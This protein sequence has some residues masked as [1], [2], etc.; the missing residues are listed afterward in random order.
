V[1]W[2]IAVRGQNFGMYSAADAVFFF[3]ALGS[4][5]ES[6]AGNRAWMLGPVAAGV[7]AAFVLWT[8]SYCSARNARSSGSHARPAT[9]QG[10]QQS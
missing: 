4:G 7:I 10:D 9:H 1:T 3:V 5:Y 2:P 6:V 8:L